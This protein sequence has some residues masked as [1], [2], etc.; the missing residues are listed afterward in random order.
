VRPSSVPTNYV[1]LFSITKLEPNVLGTTA[2]VSDEI[3]SALC[4]F[5]DVPEV[6]KEL[7]QQRGIAENLDERFV[8][9]QSFIRQSKA[10]YQAAKISGARA[11]PLNYYYAFLNLAKAYLCTRRTADVAGRIG[12]GL[13][14]DLTAASLD[15]QDLRVTPNGVFQLLYEAFNNQSVPTGTT[16]NVLSLLTYCFDISEEVKTAK[17]AETSVLPGFSRAF[18]HSER[19]ESFAIIGIPNFELFERCEAAKKRFFEHFEEVKIAP[20][21]AREVFGFYGEVVDKIRFF[22]LRKRPPTV[23]AG[24]MIGALRTLCQE[25]IGSYV[26]ENPYFGEHEC[27]FLL[28]KPLDNEGKVPFSP[29]LAIYACFFLLSSLVRY[30]PLYFEKAYASRDAWIIEG[31]VRSTPITLL[32]YLANAI[33]NQNRR[34]HAK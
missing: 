6:G 24:I 27:D 26:V 2:D 12:H 20:H 31:F 4:Y 30:H 23:A 13:T 17:G 28:C 33:F 11:S 10:F 5:A 34:Y 15:Q 16:F 22:E 14:H 3:Y 8:A 7:L 29:A 21:L 18:G 32:R 1:T 19:K 25:G 9:M